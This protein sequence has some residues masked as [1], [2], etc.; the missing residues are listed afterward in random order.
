VALR[1]WPWKFQVAFKFAQLPLDRYDQPEI[2]G[3]R[4]LER[5]QPRLFG[6]EHF[7]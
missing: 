5:Q 6:V 3:R 1:G 2:I 4:I 7:F